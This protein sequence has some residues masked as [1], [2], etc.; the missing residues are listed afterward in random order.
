MV[1]FLAIHCCL[2]PGTERGTYSTAQFPIQSV[3]QLGTQSWC[4]RWWLRHLT[5]LLQ[6]LHWESLKYVAANVN[7][8]FVWRNVRLQIYTVKLEKIEWCKSTVMNFLTDVL[9]TVRLSCKPL[10]AS[11]GCNGKS[12]VYLKQYSRY[13]KDIDSLTWQV[14]VDKMTT[15]PYPSGYGVYTC[16][17]TAMGALKLN[18]MTSCAAFQRNILEFSL[19]PS[20]LAI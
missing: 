19:V 2:W 15:E 4:C 8:I 10:I 16:M 13:A 9:W 18:K 17:S 11:I 14:L 20:P 12:S 7:F 5:V 1:G 3:S 6:I